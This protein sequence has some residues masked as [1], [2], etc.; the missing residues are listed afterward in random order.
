[1]TVELLLPPPIVAVDRVDDPPDADVFPAEAELVRGAVGSRRAEFTTARH[2]ARSALRGLGI[3]PVPIL[4]GPKREPLWPEGITG[5]IT[6]CAGYRAAAVARTSDFVTIGLDAKPNLPTPE[7]VLDLIA[8]PAELD[9]FPA[10]GAT[11]EPVCWDRLLF[12]A[13]E[14]VYKAWYPIMKTWLGFEE[15]EVTIDPAGTFS[16][17]LLVGQPRARGRALTG[18]DGRWLVRDGILVTAIALPA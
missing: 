3:E 11:G 5:S 18:F 17:W 15:A 8:R 10:D 16:A 13:K 12:S 4:S 14:S 9:R 2:C 7:G 1:M 6:H